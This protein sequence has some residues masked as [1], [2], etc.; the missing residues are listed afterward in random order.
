[1]D[2][3]GVPRFSS[4]RRPD[5]APADVTGAGPG[6]E[7]ASSPNYGRRRRNGRR[8]SRREGRRE[9]RRL[10][11]E[12]QREGSQHSL[13]TESDGE[14]VTGTPANATNAH[15]NANHA[16]IAATSPPGEHPL[17]LEDARGDPRVA[18]Y[19][20]SQYDVPSYYRQGGSL[21]LGTSGQRI[22]LES[23]HENALVLHIPSGPAGD[24]PLHAMNISRLPEYPR[25]QIRPNPT[26]T[27]NE[28]IT[29]EHLRDFISTEAPSQPGA[30]A[31]ENQ[32]K[33]Y[34]AVEIPG[35]SR[36]ATIEDFDGKNAAFAAAEAEALARNAELTKMVECDP[37][38]ISTWLCLAEH[39]ELVIAGTRYD[40]R[41]LDYSE[42]Q[43]VAK[44]KLSVYEQ[45]IQVNSGNHSLDHLLLGRMEEGAKIWDSDELDRE[46][47]KVLSSH[48]EFLSL[49]IEYLDHRQT[50]SASFSLETCYKTYRHCLQLANEFG[51]GLY[52][53]QIRSYLFLRMTLLLRESG[54]A[55]LAVGL[56]QAVLEFT[57]F[58]PT[59]LT[60]RDQTLKQFQDL[61]APSNARIGERGWKAWNS[62]EA[63]R[64]MDD[65]RHNF[66]PVASLPDL[67]G[68][69][70]KAERELMNKG[71]L[72]NHSFDKSIP[73]DPPFRAVLYHDAKQILPYF[74]D[75]TDNFHPLI[76]GFLYFSHLPALASEE[77]IRGTRL[78]SGD[79]F[80]RNEYMDDSQNT[81]ADWIKLQQSGETTANEPFAFPHQNF[82]HM[83]DTLFA[84][85]EHWFS[86]LSKWAEN[87]SHPSSVIDQ[88]FTRRVVYG[89]ADQCGDQ[90]LAEYSIA[91]TFAC[92]KN[93][94]KRYGKHV[95][96]QQT[97][98][99]KI[100]N[101]TALMQWRTENYDQATKAWSNALT[102]SQGFNSTEVVGSALIWIS[103]I[104][105]LLHT[106]Q[107]GRVAY[108]LQAM[109]SGEV[110]M[111]AYAAA[112]EIN[113]TPASFLRLDRFLMAAQQ[114][115]FN[116]ANSQAYAAYT[117]CH[118]IALYIMGDPLTSILKDYD[119]AFAA[120]DKLPEDTKVF[121]GEI[122]HQSRA[123]FI[124]MWVE[125]KRGQFS[126]REIRERLLQSLQWW[127]HNT[128]FLSLFK[129]NDARV[130]MM[131][132]TRDIF[133]V[134]GRGANASNDPNNLHRVPI[135]TH[136]FSIYIEMGRPV[137]FGSTSH[138]IRAAFERA[139]AG[140][141][142]SVGKIPPRKHVYELTSS[143]SAQNSLTLWRLYFL[144]ELYAEQ[145]VTRAREVYFRAVR[146]CP[147][148]KELYMLGF[149]H[150]RAD[151][152]AALPGSRGT[153]GGLA[154][155][156]GLT[157]PELRAMYMEMA[158]RGLRIHHTVD[159]Y[160]GRKDANGEVKEE[161]HD[162][163]V[164]K[165][166]G[167]EM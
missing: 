102:I 37:Q 148:A 9:R 47:E 30:P 159:G 109:P 45:A 145:N 86:S 133:E 136:L 139:L 33:D 155:P 89:L 91:L 151:L 7:R 126:P 110:D 68:T 152:T 100:M 107:V 117:D 50:E 71:Q 56:W 95:Q 134:A 93:M 116:F 78:W 115:A 160:W 4:F 135:T 23:R 81:I 98:N 10:I 103:W 79:E 90:E 108:L 132:R 73:W 38:D 120:L 154:T 83:T 2:S 153:S 165:M 13:V 52:K 72:P 14:N 69:W 76:N 121:T 137:T 15:P 161:G 127:P 16:T 119:I 99:L 123:R 65:D 143:V 141:G 88:H 75:C 131:D 84:D 101:T 29:P 1:M 94:G 128:L 164:V 35:Q 129:W 39:Q 150:L 21:V 57:C 19:G 17:Y 12:Q 87:T 22:T 5:A 36:T 146:S 113:I 144:F 149:E 31:D 6:D 106:G 41:P 163:Q 60:D 26:A 43:L 147:W 96:K 85:P 114:S 58:R 124:H 158:R 156:Q 97:T 40:D 77:N 49:W 140:A 27:A 70:A 61:W 34:R 25:D 42:I 162:E 3:Q 28:F 44:A 138:S 142:T 18:T 80:L 62:G 122:L 130:I 55:E 63:S 32:F 20:I 8:E 82:I 112:D 125:T 104:W 157:I 74:W 67:F 66:G 92:D 48:S 24:R 111:Q 118:A 11:E 46:W 167:A 59:H 105:E 64:R 166:E 53:N 51:F 54:Y